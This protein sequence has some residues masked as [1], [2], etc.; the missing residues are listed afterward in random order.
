MVKHMLYGVSWDFIQNIADS[1]ERDP[2][3]FAVRKVIAVV[4]VLEILPVD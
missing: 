3:S 1:T 2:P 4:Q